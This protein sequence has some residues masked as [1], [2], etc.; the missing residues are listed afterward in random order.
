MAITL[1]EPNSL[2]CFTKNDVAFQVTATGYSSLDN[3][4]INYQVSVQAGYG[5]G[6]FEIVAKNV[7]ALDANGIGYIRPRAIL[8]AAVLNNIADEDL[9]PPLSSPVPYVYEISRVFKVQV[10][11]EYG[12]PLAPQPFV[13]SADHLAILGGVDE[14]FYDNGNFFENLATTPIFF[15]QNNELK[16]IGLS[17]PDFMAYYSHGGETAEVTITKYA[18][19]NTTSIVT[20]TLALAAQEVGVFPVGPPALGDMTDI[21]RYVVAIDDPGGGGGMTAGIRRDFFIDKAQ[22]DVYYDLIYM[23]GFYC[24]EVFRCTGDIDRK[25]SVERYKS[26]QDNKVVQY[27]YD[28]D[29]L[30]TLRTGFIPT[31]MAEALQ[32]LFVYNELYEINY[33]TEKYILLDLTDNNYNLTRTRRYLHALTFEA[34]YSE[35]K[36][37]ISIR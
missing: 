20:L 23:N 10:W 14:D 11:E 33:E 12:I 13:N 32:E 9:L 27:D 2:S 22:D 25:L 18:N 29:Q 24:P 15:T 28:F 36:K 30:V 4:R 37:I 8:H 5:T 21:Y 31:S 34:R 35:K 26:L 7:V 19:D 6:D 1:T 16:E 3:Y 17:Q